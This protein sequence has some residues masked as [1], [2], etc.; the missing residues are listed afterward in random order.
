MHIL[1]V[2]DKGYSRNTSYTLNQIFTFLLCYIV[3]HISV[4][5]EQFMVKTK[6]KEIDFN[7]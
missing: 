6:I 4:M 3:E 5:Y 2:P 7:F 1:C